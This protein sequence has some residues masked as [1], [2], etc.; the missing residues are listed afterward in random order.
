M[1]SKDEEK[2]EKM[3][4]EKKSRFGF[5][6]WFGKPTS[7]SLAVAS[8]PSPKVAPSR[9]E[10]DVAPKRK[11]SKEDRLRKKTSSQPSPTRVASKT[12]YADKQNVASEPPTTLTTSSSS[13]PVVSASARQKSKVAPPAPP[14]SGRGSAVPSRS[15]S[16]ALGAKAKTSSRVDEAKILSPKKVMS[17]PPPAPTASSGMNK[18]NYAPMLSRPALDQSAESDARTTKRKGRKTSEVALS[19]PVRLATELGASDL[20]SA[21][22]GMSQDEKKKAQDALRERLKKI[23]K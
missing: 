14:A 8:A 16:S 11:D 4:M 2:Q 22:S 17:K 9:D 3:E 7:S 23:A 6:S 15:S 21:V 20:S 12:S 13:T 19:K 5:L 18:Q 1:E 10:A